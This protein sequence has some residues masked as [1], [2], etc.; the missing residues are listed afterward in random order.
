M[1]MGC[2]AGIALALASRPRGTRNHRHAQDAN[3]ANFLAPAAAAAGVSASQIRWHAMRTAHPMSGPTASAGVLF[4][5]TCVIKY[6]TYIK[7]DL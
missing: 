6:N 5:P 1:H 7:F 4:A 3:Q 2:S